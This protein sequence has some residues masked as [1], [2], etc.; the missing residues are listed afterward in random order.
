LHVAGTFAVGVAAA[1]A[2]LVAAAVGAYRLAL[3]NVREQMVI[4]AFHEGLYQRYRTLRAQH[5]AAEAFDMAS[6]PG[7][8]YHLL[9]QEMAPVA[10]A[11]KMSGEERS[12]VIARFWRARLELRYQTDQVIAKGPPNDQINA[13]LAPARRCIGGLRQEVTKCLQEA[14]RSGLS[15]GR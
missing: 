6:Q 7:S 8:A 3:I 5:D 11:A 12:Q 14:E 4:P 10:G 9:V 2:A 1:P 13:A 15:I